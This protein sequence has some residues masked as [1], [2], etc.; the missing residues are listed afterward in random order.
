MRKNTKTKRIEPAEEPAVTVVTP[1]EPVCETPPAVEP[2]VELAAATA[3]EGLAK[4]TK[5]EAEDLEKQEAVVRNHVGATWEVAEALRV[6][7]DKRL[8]KATH[9]KFSDYCLER[10]NFDRAHGDRLVKAGNVYRS[11]KCLQKE[12]LPIPTT[13]AQV[14]PL[15]RLTPDKYEDVWRAAVAKAEGGPITM[16]L[17]EELAEPHRP[18]R[19][20]KAKGDANPVEVVEATPAGGETAEPETKEAEVGRLLRRLQELLEDCGDVGV[21]DALFKLN[22]FRGLERADDAATAKGN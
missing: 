17:V 9:R 12:H 22:A 6:I 4:L 11:L 2:E 8:Y 16:K 20:V 3:A 19:E 1:A 14:R 15:T 5:K 7:H 18:K 21:Q 10:W 13:E